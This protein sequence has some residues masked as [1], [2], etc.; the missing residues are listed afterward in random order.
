MND[1]HVVV[2]GEDLGRGAGQ[3]APVVQPHLLALLV[4][5]VLDGLFDAV[6]HVRALGLAPGRNVGC[7]QDACDVH[8]PLLEACLGVDFCLALHGWR[9]NFEI[10][11][12]IKNL[13]LTGFKI[14]FEL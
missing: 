10:I 6:E 9:L 7:F 12:L 13:S 2:H 1:V 4:L 8:G 3:H 5:H 14:N 11:Y